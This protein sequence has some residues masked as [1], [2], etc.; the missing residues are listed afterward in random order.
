MLESSS[1]YATLKLVTG[2][3]ILAEVTSMEEN[4][5]D[6][7]L[8]NDPIVINE[9]TQ[10]DPNKGVAVSGLI[11]KKWQMYS[12]DSMTIIYK[13]HVISI[14]ELD[15]FGT[16]FYSKALLAAKMSSPIKKKVETTDTI[17]YVGKVDESRDF[18]ED[19]FNNSLD[20]PE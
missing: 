7:F 9:T 3:E 2:E 5:V 1:Y 11:P 14:S 16:E 20:V 18:L 15:K 13:N 4:D 6:F 17:G 19:L 10:I 12:N 8:V